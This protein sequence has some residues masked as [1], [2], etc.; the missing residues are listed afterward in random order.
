MRRCWPRPRGTGVSAHRSCRR[1]RGGPGRSRAV[2][3]PG[4]THE[5][6]AYELLN[7][8]RPLGVFSGG[9]LIVGCCPHGPRV[10]GAQRGAGARLV[11]APSAPGEARRRRRGV[12]YPRCRILRFRSFGCGADVDDRHRTGHEQPAP[13]R[14]RGRI[15]H[16]L[17][18]SLGTFPPYFSPPR[19]WA[20]AT[21]ESLEVRA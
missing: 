14:V 1:R 9:S 13:C 18:D 5:H 21:G 12:A 8:S 17:L 20:D 4:H 7:A 10:A 16:E 3:T 6:T 19:C 15:R 11:L 2:A